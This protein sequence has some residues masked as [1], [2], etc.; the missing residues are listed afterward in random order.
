MGGQH[1]NLAS[2]FPHPP[3]IFLIPNWCNACMTG[4]QLLAEFSRKLYKMAQTQ[5]SKNQKKYLT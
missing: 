4:L 5:C 1:F 2:K 3:K